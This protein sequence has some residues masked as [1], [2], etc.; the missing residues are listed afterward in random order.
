[1]FRLARNEP[2]ESGSLYQKLICMDGTEH[3]PMFLPC[4]D[5]LLY[6]CRIRI[7]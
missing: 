7:G 2:D 6:L 5:D 1:M 3:W 4:L